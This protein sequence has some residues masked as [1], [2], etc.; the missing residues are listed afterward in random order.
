R[1]ALALLVVLLGYL[2]LPMSM[3][4]TTVAL[5]GI[6]RDLDASGAAL[7]WVVTGYILAAT[8]VMLIAGS[9]GDLF[10][11]RKVYTAGIALYTA[12]TLAAAGAQG[13]LF[14][15]AARTLAGIGA[16]GVMTSGVAILSGMYEGPARARVFATVGTTAGFGIA[17]G[18]TLSGQLVAA[19]GWR[20]S[21]LLFGAV[22]V[23]ILPLTR[24]MPESRAAERPKVDR[25]G[26]ASFVA[27]LALLMY[28]VTRGGESG[29]GSPS[30]LGPLAGGAAL[31]AV[32]VAVE[33]RG[34]HPVLD[35]SLV[36]DRTFTG[37]LLGA[38]F[39]VLG[40]TGVTVYLPT[41]LQGTGGHSAAAAGA[42]MLLMTVPVFVLPSFAGWLVSSRE[43]P[44]RRLL[45]TS[46]L[47]SAAGN[48]WLALALAPDASPARLAA[49][50]VLIGIANGLGLGQID[51]Q[52][53]G[54]V[55]PDRVGM[56]SGLL[57]TARGGAG[58]LALAG[59]G[60]ALLSLVESRVGDAGLADRVASGR[61]AEVA[62]E[63][64][65]AWRTLVGSVAVVLAL[66][67][68]LVHRLLRDRP[69]PGPG[70]TGGS[71]GPGTAESPAG[72]RAPASAR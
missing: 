3:T 37:W 71:G 29:W 39:V 59:F 66:A 64:T 28:A 69:V 11:R 4:G 14:L 40:S 17:I 46:L 9:L 24:L 22:A 33:R 5:P 65:D 47:L 58:A 54:T 35:L 62:G 50:L 15:D 26:I 38:T 44:A 21:F 63:F 8:S 20:A 23:V 10:G 48:L 36:R 70:S 12:G 52:A 13:I 51:A 34:D 18:P 7:Q 1:P 32:F 41:Y 43:V 57:S 72:T 31:L 42:F 45:L 2:V 30:V 56:A 53:L 25:P 67:A 19:F 60:A 49:P 55:A 27:G 61:T 6:G 16:A 68:V